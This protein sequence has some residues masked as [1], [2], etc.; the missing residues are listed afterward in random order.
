MR[1]REA[2]HH[3]RRGLGDT[4]EEGHKGAAT[5][6]AALAVRCRDV[7]VVFPPEGV[8]DA[9]EWKARGATAADVE[10]AIEV[11]APARLGVRVMQPGVRP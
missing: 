2:L 6:A 5:L 7:R 8:K 11:S 10:A 3:P 4:D 9:R 1:W